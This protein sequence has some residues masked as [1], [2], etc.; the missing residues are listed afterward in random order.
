MM[1]H[2]SGDPLALTSRLRAIA[3]AVDPNHPA[4]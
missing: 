1:I 2:A 4:E 3:E